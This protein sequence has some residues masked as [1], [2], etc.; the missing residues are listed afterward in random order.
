VFLA[1]LAGCTESASFTYTPPTPEVGEPVV[2][3]A[4]E[5]RGDLYWFFE[6]D[7]D[8]GFLYLERA[9]QHGE[10]ASYTFEEPGAHVVTLVAKGGLMNQSSSEASETVYVDP[11]DAGSGQEIDET[12]D[13]FSIQLRGVRTNIS[14]SD[15]GVLQFSAVNHLDSGPMTVL[16]ILRAPDDVTVEESRFVDSGQGMY[17]ST[18]ELDPGESTGMEIMISPKRTGRFEIKGEAIF[19][20]EDTDDAV[21]QSATIPI[22]VSD[23]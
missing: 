4:S 5:S 13:R 22:I 1:T 17:T 2:F 18:T 7:A 15:M 8:G 20:F 23:E 21:S 9:E 3:D 19:E 6:E 10:T 11:V 14:S 16:L 12:T